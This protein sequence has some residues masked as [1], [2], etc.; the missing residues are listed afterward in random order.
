MNITLINPDSPGL[1]DPKVFPPLGILYLSAVLKKAGHTVKVI[2]LAGKGTNLPNLDYADI[3]GITATTAQFPFAIE[4]YWKLR[5]EG[6]DNIIIGGPHATID[7]QSCLRV[8]FDHVIIGE[9]EKAI[10]D[11]INYPQF[12]AKK[13]DSL[14]TAFIEDLD[15][16]P[17]PDRN[18]IDLKS[19]HYELDGR[20]CTNIISSRGCPY[21]CAFCCK[22]WGRKVRYRSD[23]P[24]VT[25]AIYLRANYGYEA[26]MFY[27]DEMLLDKKRD[28][29]IFRG[30]KNYDITFRCFSRVDI[31]KKEDLQR[32]KNLGCAQIC[33]G[34]ES[35]SNRILNNINKGFT[36]ERAKESIKWCHEVGLSVKTFV[37][38]GLPGET[39]ETLQETEN[40]LEQSKPDD[41][42]FT[43]LTV[44]P[45]TDIYKNPKR[46]DLNFQYRP[47][48]WYKTSPGEYKTTVSTKELTSE[49]ILQARDYLEERF[50]KW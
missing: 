31:V 32:L 35:G 36:I 6:F 28:W 50:K 38:V 10:L 12:F 13:R 27:D 40:F 45:N 1:M 30:L 43:V 3:T 9:G 16:L 23:V 18:S 21:S 14:Q 5:E 44:Y 33:F 34:V 42:D 4:L 47:G 8:G 2:D 20:K 41:V 24:V 26:I 22:N 49:E 39:S 25:E 17:W 29:A 7:P 15:S 19:Y 37:I 11:H 48:D 46:Y